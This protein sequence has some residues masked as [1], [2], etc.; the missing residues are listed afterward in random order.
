MLAIAHSE[1]HLKSR[2]IQARIYKLVVG[3]LWELE[4]YGILLPW[5]K[6]HKQSLRLEVQFCVKQLP[7]EE[8]II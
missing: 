3:K 1:S 7:Q 4:D 8:R 2:N 5:D 6:E